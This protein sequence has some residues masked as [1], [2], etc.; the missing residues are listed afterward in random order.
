MNCTLNAIF[1]H[2]DFAIENEQG[3]IVDPALPVWTP[4][5]EAADGDHYS[6]FPALYASGHGDD[7]LTIEADLDE[8]FAGVSAQLLGYLNGRMVFRSDPSKGGSGAWK[9]SVHA[10]FNV[11]ELAMI[12]GD[13]H[14]YIQSGQG[15][16]P[17]FVATTRLE[18]TWVYQQPAALF[19]N[20][21]QARV[22]RLVFAAI[23]TGAP[24]AAVIS[25]IVRLCYSWF[26]KTYDTMAGAPSY[27]CI[28]NG[29]VFE[30][31][32]YLLHHEQPQPVNSQDQ[33]A[34][35]Q[36]LLG[37]LGLAGEWRCMQPF[38]YLRPTNLI[39]TGTCNSPFFRAK[40]TKPVVDEDDKRRTL[41]RHH[42]FISHED[43]VLDACA[44]PREGE[45]DLERY[46]AAVID[47]RTGLSNG[48]NTGCAAE[49]AGRHGVNSLNF[50]PR[51]SE[52][53]E[54]PDGMDAILG[55]REAILAALPDST[56]SLDWNALMRRLCAGYGLTLLNRSITPASDGVFSRWTLDSGP[57]RLSTIR[58]FA[59]Q[60]HETALAR[61][62]DCLAAFENSPAAC[63]ARQDDLGAAGLMSH[64]RE[65]VLFVHRNM[66]VLVRSSAGHALAMARELY[67]GVDAAAPRH[68]RTVFTHDAFRVFPGATKKIQTAATVRHSLTGN[69]VRLTGRQRG[70]LE[71]RAQQLGVSHLRLANIDDATLE[72]QLH[73]VRIEVLP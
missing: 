68:R 41:L 46:L 26:N 24:R 1:A 62:I 60:N 54:L 25:D 9:P 7:V 43:T 28:G 70:E 71:V 53:P 50:A 49:V 35:L 18:L 65:I 30:L 66:F 44:G 6:F 5:L 3:A 52:V 33:A 19:E 4:A 13:V 67:D 36:T 21:S 32:D 59:G 39:G 12:A 2:G 45:Y 37:S 56:A 61:A 27:S 10:T 63:L 57:G 8:R 15:A 16:N 23:D 55:S 11:G 20:L 51:A 42:A 34:V 29:G 48:D 40:G 22:L 58:V 72:M 73:H 38:G 64:D 31:S 47:D 69:A 14:W 17:Q